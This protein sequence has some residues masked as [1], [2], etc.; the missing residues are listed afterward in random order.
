[1]SVKRKRTKK[2]RVGNLFIGGD[3]TISVQSMTRTDTRDVP[4][5]IDQIKKLEDVGCE[6]VRCAVPDL[7]AAEVLARIKGGIS[8][9]LVADIHF[10]HRLALKAIESG[11][12]KIR[13]N[14]GNIGDETRIQQVVR[15]AKEREIPI[16][17]GVNSG[18]LEKDILKR[19]GEATPEAM[20][21]SALRHIE[22]LESLNYDTIIVSLKASNIF[23]T[24]KAYKILSEKV[25]YPLHI[26]ITEAGSIFSGSIR[27]AVGL[28]ILLSEG[29]GDT[30]RV[31]L[32]GDPLEEVKVGKEILR[33]IGLKEDGVIMI[34][35]PI[36]GR[37]NIDMEKIAYEIERGLEHVKKPLK[38]AVMGCA[39]N[40]PGEAMEADLGITGGKREGL[41][42]KNGEILRKV[43]EEDLVKEFLKEV[44]RILVERT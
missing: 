10:D 36:C 44:E 41:I 17:V 8:I 22:I 11:V 18:S 24:L 33:S 27:S 14:P 29:I 15:K 30:I 28:G 25:N 23:R 5:T 1:M 3:A 40:G 43:K 4:K 20:V 6:I 13:I 19:F 35:C 38:I 21:E 42:Y 7:E 12:D 31:S 37:C 34:S 26:G 9:P 16:R 39:V 32:T 2:I